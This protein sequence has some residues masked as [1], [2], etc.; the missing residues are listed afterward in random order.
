MEK[1][2]CP[3]CGYE[4]PPEAKFCINCGYKF[5]ETEEATSKYSLD[6]YLYVSGIL[7]VVFLLDSFLNDVYRAMFFS[8]LFIPYM[9]SIIGIIFILYLFSKKSLDK[10]SHLKLFLLG[11]LLAGIGGLIIYIIPILTGHIAT[12]L[13]WILFLLIGYKVNKLRRS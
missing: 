4:N 13:Y 8:V 11:N 3:R 12:S 10:E 1:K 5:P 2:I 9:I 6:T 7:A